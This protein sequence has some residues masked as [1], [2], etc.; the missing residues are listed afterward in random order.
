M[1]KAWNSDGT[2]GILQSS[3]TV[4]GGGS[5]SSS[6]SSSSSIHSNSVN[7]HHH[8]HHHT[9]TSNLL[10]S[11]NKNSTQA[12]Q[13]IDNSNVIYSPLK[14]S[15]PSESDRG[16]GNIKSPFPSPTGKFNR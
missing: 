14:I 15:I 2:I 7:N 3:A 13:S 4:V 5:S 10:F 12:H 16:G 8:P 11:N 9:S 1:N 6:S